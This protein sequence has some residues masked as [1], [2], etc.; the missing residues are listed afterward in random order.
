MPALGLRRAASGLAPGRIVVAQYAE[1]SPAQKET[2]AEY[3]DNELFPVLTPLVVDPS[4]P[5]PFI[6]HLSLNLAVEME[7]RGTQQRFARVKVPETLPRLVLLPASGPDTPIVYVWIEQILAANIGRL[8]PG[9]Q[10]RAVNAFRI[11]R[12]VDLEIQED[13]T[14][15][16]LQTME[17]NVRQRSF[18]DVVRLEMEAHASDQIQVLLSQYLGV[19]G[20]ELYLS[21]GPLGLAAL[22]QLYE[23]N[24]PDLKDA[25]FVPTKPAV[26]DQ[27]QDIFAAI[28][29]GDILLHHP[30]DTFSTVVELIEAAAQDPQ[31]LAIKQTLYR[32]GRNSPIVRAL[33]RPR[34]R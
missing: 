32:A 25:P 21:S 6:S 9:T 1:L 34:K 3:F 28:R 27:G 33:M 11:T 15:D 8:F 7:G 12:D 23:I 14:V 4:H 29:A 5:F 24:R 19:Q 20:E 31:V 26:L 16:L 2:L 18:G 22:M 10:I 17:E 30:Y 13:E